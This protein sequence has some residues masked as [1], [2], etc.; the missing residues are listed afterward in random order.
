[1]VLIMAMLSCSGDAGAPPLFQG[2][3][4]IQSLPANVHLEPVVGGAPPAAFASLKY[5]NHYLDKISGKTGIN[6]TVK[7]AFNGG[8][9][10]SDLRYYEG[11]IGYPRFLPVYNH[12]EGNG[13]NSIFTIVGFAAVRVMKVNLLGNKK[14]VTLQPIR[15]RNH[16]MSVRLTR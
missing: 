13:T 14:Y 1:M 4:G 9:D 15:N 2:D 5:E 10:E 7:V 11:I 12:V 16:L 3:P 8:W 6:T